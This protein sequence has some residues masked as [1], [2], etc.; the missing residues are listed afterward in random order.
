M[1]VRERL[2]TDAPRSVGLPDDNP[3]LA[4]LLIAMQWAKPSGRIAFLMHARLL[5]K[6]SAPG[7]LARRLVF[8]ALRVR[9]ILNGA[10]LRQT[11]V[12]PRV[13]APF[14][15]ILAEN[16]A[17][18]SADEFTYASPLIDDAL[19]AL[20]SFRIDY[21][22]AQPVW[23]GAVAENTYL[24]KIMFR[25]SALDLPVLR[26]IEARGRP[27]REVW[28]GLGLASGDGF[29]VGGSARQRQSAE[30]LHGLPTLTSRKD[31]APLVDTRRLLPFRALP[32]LRPRSREIYRAPVVLCPVAPRARE[33]ARW[34]HL[35]LGDVVFNESFYGYS[36]HGHAEAEKLARYLHLVLS[37]DLLLYYVLLTSSKLGVEREEITKEDLD[38]LPLVPLESLPRAHRD[39]IEALSK[40]FCASPSETR[41]EVNRFVMACY[42][43]GDADLQVVR[44][45]LAAN[46]PFEQSRNWGQ[47]PATETDLRRFLSEFNDELRLL[48][49]DDRLEAT[50]VSARD[51]WV[52]FV[53]GAASQ[54]ATRG[55]VV[56]DT[57]ALA[58]AFGSS[59]I[60]VIGPGGR[61]ITI[62]M[63]NQMRYLTP[64]RGRLCARRL[65][66]DYGRALQ[67]ALL[68]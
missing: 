49:N 59:Q 2:G 32:V 65:S 50:I 33:C 8:R 28:D 47:Q 57:C 64:S 53:I 1:P 61:G 21:S 68:G 18:G 5:F 9:S 60:V 44:D 42:R 55:S 39:K 7:Q 48:R 24:F 13:S 66:E 58:E 16:T 27:L 43:L 10:A 34:A 51:A 25:G 19:N 38:R 63:I 67:Q 52:W 29:Q 3:D 20:G 14:C 17:P 36:T 30:A 56:L 15:F 54:D 26:Q 37:S 11:S 6:Q 45:T 35:A 62:A 41:A 31:L 12:W 22:A 40:A 23:H 4:F 46:L